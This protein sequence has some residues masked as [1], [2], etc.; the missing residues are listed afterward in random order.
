MRRAGR[1]ER[2]GGAESRRVGR[3][4]DGQEAGGAACVADSATDA[5]YAIADRLP[6]I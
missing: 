5:A 6:S 3:G 1:D 4:P 2:A